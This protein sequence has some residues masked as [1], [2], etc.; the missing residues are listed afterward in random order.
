MK[1]GHGADALDRLIEARRGRRPTPVEPASADLDQLAA[2][3][4]RLDESWEQAAPLDARAVRA[5]VGPA[6]GTAPRPSGRQRTGRFARWRRPSW[7]GWTIPRRA[8]LAASAVIGAGLL[9]ALITPE[10]Q[11]CRIVADVERLSTT[12]AEA[13]ADEELTT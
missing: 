8:M 12:A 10:R 13:L 3:G 5:R 2:A 4:E 6:L 7:D 9:F 11:L 1:R